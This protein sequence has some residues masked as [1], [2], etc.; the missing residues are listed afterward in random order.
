MRVGIQSQGDI[1]VAQAFLDDLGVRALL[2][3]ERGSSMAQVVET[4]VGQAGLL[5]H[6]LEKPEQIPVLQWVPNRIWEDQVVVMPF[7]AG[8]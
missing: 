5:K 4:H 8:G 6:F 7:L 2:Q 3:H 1:S